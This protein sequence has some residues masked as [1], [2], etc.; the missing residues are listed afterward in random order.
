MVIGLAQDAD[1]ASFVLERDED[2]NGILIGQ[3]LNALEAANESDSLMEFLESLERGMDMELSGELYVIDPAK[4]STNIQHQLD[5]HQ[6]AKAKT[7]VLCFSDATAIVKD[8]GTKVSLTL[9]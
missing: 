3:P 6:V 5:G 1:V 9:I 4:R 2:A 7:L 8:L